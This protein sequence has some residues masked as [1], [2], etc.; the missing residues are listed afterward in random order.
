MIYC[1]KKEECKRY[2]QLDKINYCNECKYNN[3]PKYDFF[4]PKIL[5]CKWCGNRNVEKGY[6]CL[7]CGEIV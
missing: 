1:L 2:A 5:E 3:P 7:N 6:K 4:E